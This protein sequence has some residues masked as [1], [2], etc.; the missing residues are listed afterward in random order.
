M[1]HSEEKSI[2]D[3]SASVDFEA[4]LRMIAKLSAPEGLEERVQ[5]GLRATPASS[6]GQIIAWPTAPR[7]GGSWL[8]NSLMRAAAAAAIVAVIIGGSWGVYSR[9]QSSQ[10]ARVTTPLTHVSRQGGFSSA[11]A[12]R[13]P[14][15]LNGPMVEHPAVTPPATVT[16]LPEKPANKP[17]VKTPLN[18]AKSAAAGKPISLRATSPTK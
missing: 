5:A 16:A 13:T 15:T 14:Q 7:S 4:T 1:N 12:M 8:H 11:G 18:P 6:N 3:V 2:T 10:A 17:A 9:V